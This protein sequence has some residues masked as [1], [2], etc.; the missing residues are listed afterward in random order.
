MEKEI[1]QINESPNYKRIYNDM[2]TKKYPQKKE[3]CY[4]ILQ[5]EKLSLLDVISLNLK[6]F[7]EENS[8]LNQQLRSYDKPSILEILDYQKKN[9]INNTELAAHFKISRNTV[10]KWKKIFQL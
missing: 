7:N 5:K 6:L 4:S 8:V 3:E 2:I 9:R 1:Q 10:T